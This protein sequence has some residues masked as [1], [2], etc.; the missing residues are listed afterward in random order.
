MNFT[1]FLPQN[2]KILVTSA[3]NG[4]LSHVHEWTYIWKRSENADFHIKPLLKVKIFKN[5]DLSFTFEWRKQSNLFNKNTYLS[6]MDMCP[7]CDLDQLK[8][9]PEKKRKQLLEKLYKL[10]FFSNPFYADIQNL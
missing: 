2:V 4:I 9:L 7:C 3:T 10:F 1:H 5:R 6:G 8:F